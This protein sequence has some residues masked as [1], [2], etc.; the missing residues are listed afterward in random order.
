MFHCNGTTQKQRYLYKER[1]LQKPP[2]QLPN[3]GHELQQQ[4][5]DGA[6]GYLHNDLTC[7]LMPDEQ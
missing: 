7:Y 5:Y 4:G 3:L 6:S 2:L 1:L